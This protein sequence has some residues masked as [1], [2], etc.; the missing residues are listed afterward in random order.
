[1]AALRQ[2]RVPAKHP[3]KPLTLALLLPPAAIAGW[4][5]AS[6]HDLAA[7]FK[8]S[9]NGGMPEW[10][11]PHVPGAVSPLAP[12]VDALPWIGVGVA[13]VFVLGVGVMAL[14]PASFRWLG[15]RSEN[16]LRY[17][18]KW[19][20]SMRL[21]GLTATIEG[22]LH[23]PKLIKVRS[24]E[25]RDRVLVRM[26]NS[27]T[28]DDFR[29]KAEGFAQDF[30]ALDCRVVDDAPPKLFGGRGGGRIWLEFLRTD[31]LVDEIPA[32]PIP[33][34]VDLRSVQV[35]MDDYN[36]PW[37]LPALGAHVLLGGMTGAGKSGLLWSLIRG[38]CPDI[39]S[40]VVQLWGSDAKGG[41]ELGM[42]RE[43]FTRFC[44]ED[45]KEL[46]KMLLELV[47]ISRARAARLEGSDRKLEPSVAEPLYVLVIDEFAAVISL[48]TDRQLAGRIER[49][50]GTLL[51]QGR[52]TGIHVLGA[53]Q[54][55]LKSVLT[56]RGLFSHRVA[57][58]YVEEKYADATLG[59]GARARG[60]VCD[61]PMCREDGMAFVMRDKAILPSR[62]RSA[63]VPNEL[64]RAMAVE[65]AP[66][67]KPRPVTLNNS[68][69]VGPV[70]APATTTHEF[71]LPMS[72]GWDINVPSVPKAA[73][74]EPQVEPAKADR[75]RHIPMNP[76]QKRRIDA[77]I[78]EMR[79][80]GMAIHHAVITIDTLP[81]SCNSP[82]MKGSVPLIRRDGTCAGK[83]SKRDREQARLQKLLEVQLD[84]RGLAKPL[85]K[86]GQLIV[87]ITYR[88]VHKLTEC[89]NLDIFRKALGDALRR[90]KSPGVMGEL[91]DDSDAEWLPLSEEIR[92]AKGFVG[93]T[94]RMWWREP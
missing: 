89:P 70:V 52:A 22:K 43:L 85:V 8:A 55:P 82:K 88:G 49:L 58:R 72:Q 62:V 33:E 78:A 51:S 67:L 20:A 29:K 90:S 61:G 31:P 69:A 75:G 42:G 9:A 13:S 17:R 53:I 41:M 34:K 26:V 23:A 68:P 71:E 11:P 60:A 5:Y 24:D 44:R 12:V 84:A 64:I 15:R 1:M 45:P 57:M 18:R 46:E 48:V 92:R 7:G 74:S 86:D 59:A 35:G 32:L 76:A 38:L 25:W 36:R 81:L 4:C 77:E 14:K 93:S 40:G 94:V 6:T 80:G 10:P 2:D 54:E 21:A 87:A 47:A 27:M 16:V 37:C 66:V 91:A 79:K 73:V 3:V 50:L 63:W 56:L 83:L 30:G 65:Y 39:R 19:D 28:P